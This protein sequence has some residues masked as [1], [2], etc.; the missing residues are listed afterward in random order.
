MTATLEELFSNIPIILTLVGCALML[1][2]QVVSIVK[3]Y[4]DKDEKP[5][6]PSSGAAAPVPARAHPTSVSAVAGLSFLCGL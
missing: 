3:M 1:A 2:M 5:D 4:R 6:V